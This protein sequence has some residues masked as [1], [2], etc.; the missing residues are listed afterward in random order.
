[1]S[2]TLPKRFAKKAGPIGICAVPSEAK[3]WNTR[4]ASASVGN[5]SE[6]DMHW[7]SVGP[8]FM[9]SDIMISQLFFPIKGI[10]VVY[11]REAKTFSALPGAD[12]PQYVQ[13]NAVWSP[14]GK[15]IMFAR[16]T[17]YRA[18][19][20]EQ[21]NSALVDEK[22]VPEFTVDKQPFRYDLYRIPFN[23]EIG[24]AHV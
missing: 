14:D 1:M 20:L 4:S 11:D 10:L 18:E 17:A 9:P 7:K 15:E 5:D 8:D 12:D 21:Q 2:T 22:D 24:R 13:T 19:R 6:T 16:A 3:A 23:D